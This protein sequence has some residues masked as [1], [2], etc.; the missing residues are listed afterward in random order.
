MEVTKGNGNLQNQK[1]SLFL[2]K[3][4]DLIQVT[5]ELPSFDKLHEEVDS[6]VILEYVVHVHNER[7]LDSVQNV[8][9]KLDVLKLLIINDDVLSDTFHR[10]N[11][12][13]VSILH[14]V[15]LPKSAFAH[16]LHDYKVLQP[17][18]ILL[19]REYQ[20]TSLL[21]AR[22]SCRLVL[23]PWYAIVVVFLI[24]IVIIIIFVL[25]CEVL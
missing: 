15:D 6:I 5:E 14:Q 10:I 24:L 12:L 25:V 17:R 13:C 8:L 19:P 3:P 2:C 20:V 1:A 9:L 4:L 11:L 23:H 16:H 21:H 18:I 22:S 7:M